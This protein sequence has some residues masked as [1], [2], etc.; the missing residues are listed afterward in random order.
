MTLDELLRQGAAEF[1]IALS[2]GQREAL[3]L[4]AA[5]LR[6]WNR[7]INLTAIRDDRDVVIKHF[8]DS[9]AFLRGFAPAPGLRL[10][11]MGSGA[12]FPGLVLKIARPEIN[13]TLVE[14]VKKKAAFLRHAARMLRLETTAVQD[15]RTEELSDYHGTCDVVTARAFADMT[16]AIQLGAPFLKP[17]GR[18][19]LSRG[20]EE[21]LEEQKLAGLALDPDQRIELTL[22]FSEYRRV[23]WVFK[24]H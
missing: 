13:L 5:E 1:G 20:P 2:V 8:L 11:D 9:L 7:R 22:P 19:I 3:F 15:R 24:R 16:Q 12:G 4:L 18:L 14:S 6:K 17:A 10:L 21:Q 23:I